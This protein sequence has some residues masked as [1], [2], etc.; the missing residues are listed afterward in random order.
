[1]ETDPNARGRFTDYENA[2]ETIGEPD[3]TVELIA[4]ADASVLLLKD[5]LEWADKSKLLAASTC[6]TFHFRLEVTYRTISY[7]IPLLLTLCFIAV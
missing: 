6:L 2:F 5:W 7:Q 1:M 4:D 3:Y